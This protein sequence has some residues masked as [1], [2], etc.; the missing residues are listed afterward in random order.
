MIVFL[1]VEKND[2]ISVM[3]SK[4]P[5]LISGDQFR[6]LGQHHVLCTR[7]PLLLGLD[8]LCSFNCG[9]C[10]C[11]VCPLIPDS[12]DTDIDAKENMVMSMKSCTEESL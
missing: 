11:T 4:F 9:E 8:L 5:L 7:R 10:L 12:S 6:E 1:H 2:L 3:T